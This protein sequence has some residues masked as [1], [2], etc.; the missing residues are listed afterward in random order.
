MSEQ[1][2][3]GVLDKTENGQQ[4]EPEPSRDAECEAEMLGLA[5]LGFE[6]LALY[7]R[8]VEE[9]IRDE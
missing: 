8:W 7:E 3:Q 1:Q 5:G 9:Q 6:A 4:Q 2:E